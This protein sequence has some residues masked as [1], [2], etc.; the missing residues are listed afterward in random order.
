MMTIEDC[1]SLYA[2]GMKFAANLHSPRLVEVFARLPRENISR[3]G[4]WEIVS[5]DV[6]ALAACGAA[7]NSYTQVDDPRQLYR[8]VVLLQLLQASTRL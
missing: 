1:R 7:P 2:E 6:R 8:N 3:P 5:P 4:P